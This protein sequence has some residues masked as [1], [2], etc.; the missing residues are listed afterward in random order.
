MALSLAAAQ[1]WDL[2]IVGAGVAGLAAARHATQNGL[3]NVLVLEARDRIGGRTYTVPLNI[4]LPSNAPVPP[5]VDLGA[6]WVQG[7][8]N[9]ARGLN[10]MLKLSNQA[11]IPYVNV[12]SGASSYTPEG[13]EDSDAW[14]SATETQLEK[15]LDYLAAYQETSGA[16]NSDSVAKVVD[17]YV[18]ARKLNANQRAA[19]NQSL[20]TEVVLEYADDT[21]KLS[22]RWFDQD[23]DFGGGD[24]LPGRGYGALAAYLATGL[25]VRTGHVVTGI[26]YGSSPVTVSGRAGSSAFS[27]KA[28]RVIVTM[29]LGYL[30]AQLS[31][32]SPTLFTPAI[33]KT[34]S[35]AIK[36]LG[37]GLL[38]KVILV[39]RNADWMKGILTTPWLT[40]RNPTSPGEFSE[41]YVLANTPAKLPVIVCFNAGDAARAAEALT[42]AESVRRALAP[43]R[44]V[45]QAEERKLPDPVQTIVTRWHSDPWTLGSYSYGKVGIAANTRTRAFVTLGSGRVRFAGEAAHADFPATVHGAYLSGVDAADE[46]LDE[47]LRRRRRAKF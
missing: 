42:D 31:A 5:V 9:K 37:M 43:L 11:K 22:A 27:I 41:F 18:A 36:A 33:G 34:Q 21:Q 25:T 20:E 19:L 1:T 24:A 7:V 39:W 23:L 44:H 6:A 45:A 38:N 13:V 4:S 16:S 40:V 30:Q 26:S 15:F 17:A 29:P 14:Y 32:P 10:P 8:G 2:V 47:L 46:V 28:K 12:S 35:D 3:K